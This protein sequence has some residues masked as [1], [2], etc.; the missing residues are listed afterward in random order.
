M[1]ALY[2]LITKLLLSY[3]TISYVKGYISFG[4]I[5]DLFTVLIILSSRD[6]FSNGFIIVKGLYTFIA[7]CIPLISD[8]T[9]LITG[10]SFSFSGLLYGKLHFVFCTT[11]HTCSSCGRH[12][13]LLRLVHKHLIILLIFLNSCLSICLLICVGFV[14]SLIDSSL[15][16]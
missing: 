11:F 2:I 3:W 16:H 12:L 8:Y 15:L 1:K 4:S 6:T 9:C 5:N 10:R 14:T 13:L 7:A